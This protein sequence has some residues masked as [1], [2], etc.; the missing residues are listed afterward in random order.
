LAKGLLAMGRLCGLL[1]LL[2]TGHHFH[3]G[4]AAG[5]HEW[6][7]GHWAVGGLVEGVD[8]HFVFIYLFIYLFITAMHVWMD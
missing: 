6:A 8:Y 5:C 3:H 7:C 2:L 1:H 4:K